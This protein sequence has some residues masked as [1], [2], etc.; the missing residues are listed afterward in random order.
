MNPRLSYPPGKWSLKLCLIS[1]EIN[2][3]LSIILLIQS[4]LLVSQSIRTLLQKPFSCNLYWSEEKLKA[5][6]RRWFNPCWRKKCPLYAG[7]GM[8]CYKNWLDTWMLPGNLHLLE[9]YKSQHALQQLLERS[10]S[11]TEHPFTK[12]SVGEQLK[13]Q[14]FYLWGLLGWLKSFKLDSKQNNC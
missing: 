9:D 11:C 8:T 2:Y 10:K 3:A 12:L 7:R 6:K 5:V 1:V 14:N 13:R 4:L